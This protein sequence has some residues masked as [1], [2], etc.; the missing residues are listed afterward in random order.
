G[1]YHMSKID[2]VQVLVVGAGPTGLTAAYEL[3][4]RGITCRIVDDN[5]KPTPQSR[6]LNLHARTLELFENMG[7]IDDALKSGTPAYGISVYQGNKRL[8]HVTFDELDSPY[9]YIL[10]IPQ[11]QTELVLTN[12]LKKLGVKVERPV[13]LR[14]F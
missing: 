2:D 7:L 13:S 14:S 11:H 3:T 4:R 5:E 9:P 1:I 8:V 12:A 6:A 10:L